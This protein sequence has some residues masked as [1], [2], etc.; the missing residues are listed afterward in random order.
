MAR[1]L[2]GSGAAGGSAGASPSQ[3]EGRFAPRHGNAALVRLGNQL[4]V[5]VGDVH[6][7]SDFIT[8]VEEISL[9]GVENHRSDHVADVAGFVDGRSADVDAHLAGL[10]GMEFLLPV[11]GGVVEFNGHEATRLTTA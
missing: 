6:H 8:R 9:D 2:P 5:H 4:V 7:Q 11:A 10:Q 3:V 1:T